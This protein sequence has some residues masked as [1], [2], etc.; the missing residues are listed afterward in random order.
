MSSLAPCSLT[1]STCFLTHAWGIKFHT[2]MKHVNLDSSIQWRLVR[3][4][5]GRT[6]AKI[7]MCLLRRSSRAFC[8]AQWLTHLSVAY[9]TGL[10]FLICVCIPPDVH[11]EITR[12]TAAQ[13]K[14]LISMFSA[15]DKWQKLMPSKY[16]MLFLFVS[17]L[18]L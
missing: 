1:L 7:I 14:F 18:Q 15:W 13:P 10:N 4:S 5:Y 3:L 8:G 11:W 6:G 17:I 9:L 2:F 12:P 16:V